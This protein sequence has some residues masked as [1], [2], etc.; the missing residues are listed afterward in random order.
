[1]EAQAV[2]PWPYPPQRDYQP[3]RLTFEGQVFEDV[4]IKVK[5]GCGSS[6]HTTQ[7]AGLKI[8]LNWDDPAVPGCPTTPAALRQTHLTLNNMVQDPTFE[9]ERLAYQLFRAMGVPAARP[10]TSG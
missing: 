1:M 10:P 3:G 4:G 2:G 9:R 7:K 8:S 5:G 6:R